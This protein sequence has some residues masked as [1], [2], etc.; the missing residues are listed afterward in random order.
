MTTETAARSARSG[1]PSTLSPNSGR[2]KR[3]LSGE[4]M[5][6]A[7]RL[8]AGCRT[9]LLSARAYQGGRPETTCPQ[10][11][12]SEPEALQ[13]TGVSAPSRLHFHDQL[14]V[15]RPAEQRLDLGACPH[16]DLA[17]GDA[18]LADE[19]AFLRLRL[20]EHDGADPRELDLVH[21]DGD[22]VRHLLPRELER[23]LPDH[24]GDALLEGEIGGLAR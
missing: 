21:D 14:E 20:D 16:P 1:R 10:A 6:P 23:L 8:P 3:F 18:P 11:P 13:L 19:D 22:R 2:S 5:T 17:H 4:A 15:H 9:R 7:A 12:G 24:F